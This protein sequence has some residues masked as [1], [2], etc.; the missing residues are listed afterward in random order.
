MGFIE[1]GVIDAAGDRMLAAWETREPIMKLC[2]QISVELTVDDFVAAADH[3]RRLE[4]LLRLIRNTYPEATLAMRERRER[5]VLALE[6]ATPRA[7]GALSRYD[8][9]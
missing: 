7:T 6:R 3:Q 4:N 8:E 2:G 5:K 1:Y 9:A